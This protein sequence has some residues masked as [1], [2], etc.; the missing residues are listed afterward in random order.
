MNEIQYEKWRIDD[1]VAY[2]VDHKFT[3]VTCQ[4]PDDMLHDACDV[5]NAL[6][7]ACIAKQHDAQVGAACL[8]TASVL[9]S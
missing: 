8:F 2:I 7:K 5:A 6:K 9:P 3:S 4:F 1:T